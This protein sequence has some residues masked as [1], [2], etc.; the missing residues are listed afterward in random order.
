MAVYL[1]HFDTPFRH[2]KHYMG[3]A[4]DDRMHAR[5]DAH[6][7]AKIG[8]HGHHRLMQH[9]RAAGISFTLARVW[10]KAT[11]TDERRMKNGGHARRCPICQG[12]ETRGKAS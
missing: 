12:R 11:R 1:L 9:V 7:A 5:I 6:Y 8:D 3:Y 4:R 2:A 10:L